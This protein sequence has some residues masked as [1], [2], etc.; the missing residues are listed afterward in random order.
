M[1]TISYR[2]NPLS[3]AVVSCRGVEAANPRPTTR[4]S[5]LAA[6]TS[7]GWISNQSPTFT[8]RM[9]VR[10]ASTTPMIVKK[11]RAVLTVLRMPSSSSLARYMGI[12]RL[13]A[14]LSPMPRR[15]R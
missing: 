7:S 5:P 3:T 13:I 14:L 15:M 12:R 1:L 8:A 10:I 2:C 4:T 9:S 6:R 11:N